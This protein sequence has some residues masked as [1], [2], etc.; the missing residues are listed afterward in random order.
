MKTQ[1]KADLV[2]E[3]KR[4]RF[5]FNLVS[6]VFPIIDMNLFPEYRRALKKL[7]LH[8][9]WTV[10]DLASGTGILAGAFSE[11]GHTVTGF[12]FAKRLQNRAKKRFPQVRFELFDLMN[13]N[14]LPENSYDL[15]TMGYFLHG[16]HPDF[17]LQVLREA[18]RISRNNVVV[19]DYCC[20]GNWFVRLIEWIEGP[21]YP[22]FVNGNREQDFLAAGL[23]IQKEINLSDYGSVWLLNHTEPKGS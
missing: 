14:T 12:D 13:L 22:N 4:T 21:Y 16:V 11:R 10:L 2:K 6:F 17:R 19:F 5:F 20:P 15:V 3:N 9:E 18:R 7:A 8:P 23:A 1:N